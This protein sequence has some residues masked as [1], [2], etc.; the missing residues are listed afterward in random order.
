MGGVRIHKIYAGYG[1]NLDHASFEVETMNPGLEP[2]EPGSDSHY[3]KTI[4]LDP[5]NPPA[6]NPIGNETFNLVK[7]DDEWKVIR[8]NH[9][10]LTIDDEDSEA[11]A[12]MMLQ[13]DAETLKQLTSDPRLPVRT[14][15]AYEALKAQEAK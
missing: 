14:L 12:K 15:Q 9:L 8:Q 4:P 13:M 3:R 1:Q 5:A 10:R 2:G 11:V 6:W 7:V